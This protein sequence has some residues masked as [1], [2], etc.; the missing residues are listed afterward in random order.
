MRESALTDNLGQQLRL[1]VGKPELQM[2]VAKHILAIRTQLTARLPNDSES[3][4]RLAMWKGYLKDCSDAS[5]SSCFADL[6]LGRRNVGVVSYIRGYSKRQ[7]CTS[8]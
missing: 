3:I 1:L 8:T 2:V 7:Y 6:F 5:K 4:R